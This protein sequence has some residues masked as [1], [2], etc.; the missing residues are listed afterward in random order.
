M[1]SVGLEQSDKKEIGK[2]NW[3]Q[4][5]WG[6]T[7]CFFCLYFIGRPGEAITVFWT[8]M[9][10]C[11]GNIVRQETEQHSE[12]WRTQIY[13]MPS[14]PDELTLRILGPEQR[15]HKILKG[16]CRASHYKECVTVNKWASAWLETW[17]C[18]DKSN[19]GDLLLKVYL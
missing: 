11:C 3:P 5:I 17:G 18:L 12:K 10:H 8:K 6:Y 14:V 9:W 2:H 7:F 15:I 1:S 16:Q 19:R 13:F 4:I